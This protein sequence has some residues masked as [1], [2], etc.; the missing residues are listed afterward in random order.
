MKNKKQHTDQHTDQHTKISKFCCVS[1]LN[2]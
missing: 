2:N 1:L